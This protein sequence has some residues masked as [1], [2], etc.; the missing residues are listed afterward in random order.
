M[1]T[2][3]T[4]GAFLALG[5][6]LAASAVSVFAQGN[7]GSRPGGRPTTSPGV[8]RGTDTARTNSAGRVDEGFG[9][10]SSRSNGRFDNGMMRASSQ[11]RYVNGMPTDYELN[12]FRGVAKK[13]DTTPDELRSAFDLARQTNPDLKFGQFVA[14]NVI[15]D[16]L[17]ATHPEITSDAILLGLANGDSIGKTLR[18]LGLGEDDAKDVQKQAKKEIKKSGK[19][20]EN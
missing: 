12:R 16:N 6:L 11:P 8:S 2:R 14:A 1:K 19:Q 3:K 7:S 5:F 20:A 18:N 13:L 17:S 9:T 4:L 15:A 10:A